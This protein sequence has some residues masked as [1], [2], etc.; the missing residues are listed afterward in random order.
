M[1][2]QRKKQ[3]FLSIIAC[4]LALCLVLPMSVTAA[5]G[6]GSRFPDVT[7]NDWFYEDVT[8]LSEMGII[9][10]YPNGTF[11]P[12]NEI[13]NAEFL[14]MLTQ[15]IGIDVSEELEIMLFQEHWASPYITYAYMHGIL[16][17]DELISGFDPAEPIS[18]SAM[19]K[20]MVLALG[21]ELSQID[22]PFKDTSDIYA[23]TAYNE[24]LLRGYVLADGSRVYNGEGR[25]KRSEASA[26]ISRVLAYRTD[27][28]SYKREQI[29]STALTGELNTEK[30]LIDLF[31]TLNRGFIEQFTLR[32][33]LPFEKWESYYRH[34]NLLYLE[35]FYSSALHCSY[36]PVKAPGVYNIKLAFDGT[37]DSYR[38]IQ[39]SVSQAADSILAAII[40]DGMSDTDKV[41]AI[42]DY[43]I[44][45]CAYDYD[46][47]RA[48][49]VTPRSRL[50]IGV[51]EDGLAVCQGYTAAFN[52]L[53][54]AAG[55][56]VIAVKGT[57]PGS[58]EEHAWNAV[59]LNGQLYHIDVT[60]DDPV[61]DTAGRVSY[62]YFLL[63]D[64]EMSALGYK[65]DKTQ[66]QLK[67]FY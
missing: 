49:K 17:D 24:Y 5:E 2:K 35:H 47:Y 33:S 34:A 50:V 32:T 46:N 58:T 60:H 14:K 31:H 64:E 10:G 51:F 59:L 52:L 38:N 20:M 43:L 18:R 36:D 26:I 11:Q 16:T 56:R 3:I 7:K 8:R 9:S 42:H 37:T 63:T 30:E 12:E 19:T 6:D 55:L 67:Y 48:G 65:W 66:T 41:K 44:L 25:A 61:P 13:T 39:A 23:A 22:T 1:M 40:R 62:K 27:A 53:C 21:I 45:N 54:R 28:Y 29:L 57:S 4:T 15:S